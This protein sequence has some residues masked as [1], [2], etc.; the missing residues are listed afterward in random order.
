M[1]PSHAFSLWKFPICVNLPP[2]SRTMIWSARGRWR[3]GSIVREMRISDGEEP[4]VRRLTRMC[5]K[6]SSHAVSS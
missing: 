4:R 6:D 1:Y 2:S 3:A 5:G